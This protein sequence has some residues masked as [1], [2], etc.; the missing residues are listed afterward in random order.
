M[1][2]NAEHDDADRGTKQPSNPEGS[3]AGA[4]AFSCSLEVWTNRTR[5]RAPLCVYRGQ[6]FVQRMFFYNAVAQGTGSI[7]TDLLDGTGW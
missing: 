2:V 3:Q 5:V 4:A 1:L 7:P 6:K